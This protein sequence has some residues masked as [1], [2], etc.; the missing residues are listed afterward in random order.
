MKKRKTIGF[1]IDEIR[2]SYQAPVWLNL[3]N[4]AAKMN[5]NLIAFEGK[6]LGR[7][8]LFSLEKQ[9]N[10]IY[11]L[12]D[13]SPIDG[14][15][16]LS[17]PQ[18]NYIGINRF[19]DHCNNYINI[20][21][22]S[23]GIDIPNALNL[24]IDGKTG[25]RN[26]INHLIKEHGYKRI[27]FLKG[28]ETNREANGRFQTYLSVLEENGIHVDETIIFNGDFEY[29]SGYRVA[30]YILVN[31]IDLD[32]L[33]CANDNMAA[34]AMNSLKNFKL[35]H[36]DSFYVTGFD[37]SPILKKNN[38][39]LTTVRQPFDEIIDT[40]LNYIINEDEVPEK[41]IYFPAQMVIRK[42][43]GC[44]CDFSF[45][46]HLSINP[47]ENINMEYKIYELLQTN[48]TEELFE[49]VSGLLDL[50]EIQSCYIA[51]YC[52]GP[53]INNN[54][55]AGL[56]EKSEL[57][58]AYDDKKRLEITDDIKYFNTANILPC[59]FIDNC[60]PYCYLVQPLFFNKEHYGYIVFHVVNNDVTSYDLLRGNI[61]NTLRIAYLIQENNEKQAK[62]IRSE[63]L[64]V[65][66]EISRGLV[67][68]I[69]SPANKIA[70]DI[71]AINE[72]LNTI[73][74]KNS[75]SKDCLETLN[76]IQRIL[77][78]GRESSESIISTSNSFRRQTLHM[79]MDSVQIFK[80][81]DIVNELSYLENPNHCEFFVFNDFEDYLKTD[82]N[83]L[84]FVVSSV[85]QNSIYAY[86]D[87]SGKI[88]LS[89]TS[90]NDE[91]LINIKDYASGIPENIK[92]QIFKKCF[93]EG[94]N[95]NGIG[96]GLFVSG[97]FV[98]DYF[99]GSISFETL[100]DKETTFKIRIPLKSIRQA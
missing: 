78:S 54:D 58:Y 70:E 59:K 85:V 34:G 20:P 68:I 92:N 8:T 40:A 5:C 12:M 19:I 45:Q 83:K 43:C 80:I 55:Q 17:G 21:I 72:L 11:K 71:T 86:N 35:S 65:L 97:I 75:L 98:K 2:G 42:S 4:K 25:I 41:T 18:V 89:I 93:I 69:K 50:F 39:P 37:D 66:G 74:M 28:P 38:Y 16:I 76:S 36:E 94:E 56:P 61:I 9:H 30:N 3:K 79:I 96:I 60:S 81:S 47:T 44:S 90:K 84:N 95:K 82:Y 87:I 10:F 24:L 100:H 15:I 48:T 32:V 13:K 53:V 29:E 88:E 99:H 31:K 6:R 46:E 27:G 91:L 64:G 22:V 63:K 49:K 67:N 73:K 33:V 1:M 23:I 62:L 26:L 7:D 51:K 77:D 14:L 57:I 52:D